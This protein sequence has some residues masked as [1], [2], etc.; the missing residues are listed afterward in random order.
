MSTLAHTLEGSAIARW[1]SAACIAVVLAAG[2]V[3]AGLKP[4]ERT[5]PGPAPP[6]SIVAPRQASA[7]G[8]QTTSVTAAA[9]DDPDANAHHHPAAAGHAAVPGGPRRPERHR[10]APG[11]GHRPHL[12][13]LTR[14]HFGL[15]SRRGD[16]YGMEEIDLLRGFLAGSE[17]LMAGVKDDQWELPTPCPERIVAGWEEHG[18]DRQVSL[19]GGE[20][21]GAMAFNMTVMES[22]TH[23]WDLATATGQPT[24]WSEEQAA[25]VLARAEQT[26][27]PEVRGDGMPFGDIVEVPDTA[28]AADR[29]A[30]FLGRTP[31]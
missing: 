7:T 19:G 31:P 26:L 28:P 24:P 17:D 30:A 23:S 14:R 18:F 21:P 6:T 5:G 12:R 29:V 13:G 16:T 25:D 11:E 9:D 8:S 4:G 10:P 3:S 2:L 15:P 20:S 1:G 22:L 27:P